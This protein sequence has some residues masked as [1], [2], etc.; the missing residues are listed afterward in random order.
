MNYSSS[1]I[2]SAF[3]L[4]Q[5]VGYAQ[6]YGDKEFYLVDSL[7]LELVSESEKNSLDSIL[8]LYH[9]CDQTDDTL[10]LFYLENLVEGYESANIEG[11]YRYEHLK[12]ANQVDFSIQRPDDIQKRLY[13]SKGYANANVAI[14]EVFSGEP[15]AAMAY[16]DS[17]LQ[18]LHQTDSNNY[19]ALVYNLASYSCK[20]TGQ[21]NLAIDYNME[22]LTVAEELNDP[23]ILSTVYN[24]L[25][26]LHQLLENNTKATG[27]YE[28][29]LV[30]TD[31]SNTRNYGTALV[32]FSEFL[33]RNVQDTSKALL[34]L[35]ESKS[36]ID[37]TF[38]SYQS[39]S[40]AINVYVVLGSVYLAQHN[41]QASENYY[42][43]SLSLSTEIKR[44]TRVCE[45]YLG[46]TQ[47][48]LL[49][50][51]RTQA[52]NYGK[53]A[54]LLA[55]EFSLLREQSDAHKLLSQIHSEAKNYSA[56]HFHL[57]EHLAASEEY[58]QEED[59]KQLLQRSFQYDYTKKTLVD[60]LA[61]Q[62]KLN[63]AKANE[64]L[65]QQKA[66]SSRYISMLA[67]FCVA[68]SVVFIWYM[69][70]RI[71]IIRKQKS[72]L[73]Q[74]F[75]KLE[76]SKK[77]ELASSNLKAIKSQMNPHFMFNSLNSIQHLILK[78]DTDKSYDYVVMF[79]ELVRNT[80]SYSEQEFI[81]V[82]KELD[83][84]TTYLELEKLRF[85]KDFNY[86]LKST[87]PNHI[88]VP[89]I[90]IQPFIENALK[91]GLLHKKGL[92]QLT[93]K[94]DYSE[95]LTCTIR[96]NGIGRKNSEKLKKNEDSHVSFAMKSIA[97]R[98]EILSER[99]QEDFKYHVKDLYDEQGSAAGTEIFLNMP[100]KNLTPIN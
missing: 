50:K 16:I 22:A 24:N 9:K 65:A 91:H 59:K 61:N 1:L 46:L 15:D 83:F 30:N 3:L 57:N 99:Y 80:L 94:L 54:L 19:K 81:E 89:P 10:Y 79:S 42:L 26:G 6:N 76:I 67:L 53:K 93:V 37:T 25:A 69:I 39:K 85:K 100:S 62:E 60:S 40:H 20:K 34:L 21:I 84:L 7:D 5:L 95:H 13:F 44:N 41:L 73:N 2:F 77:N 14:M 96:D 23:E 90:L 33:F 12:Q 68:L 87:V 31:K 56:A 97:E 72:E 75:K 64:E 88:Q 74:A 71:R 51:K 63:I 11:V 28:K 18:C 48:N 78:E 36:I 82:D 49:K 27:Y 4:F 92:K 66:K 8:N 86:E 38:S 58:T 43:K 70:S 98:L 35:N 29:A 52:L 47:I 55:N 45:A 17:A 32:N